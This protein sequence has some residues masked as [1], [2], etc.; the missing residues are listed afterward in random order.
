MSSHPHKKKH[1]REEVQGVSKLKNLL[2]ELEQTPVP[3]RT[4]AD[5]ICQTQR[6]TASRGTSCGTSR[7]LVR[8]Q[9]VPD[10]ELAVKKEIEEDTLEY[11]SIQGNP[12]SVTG[13]V[14]SHLPFD[15]PSAKTETPGTY[16]PFDTRSKVSFAG[17]A[18]QINSKLIQSLVKQFAG[19]MVQQ[20]KEDIQ[21]LQTRLA[22]AE[23]I[24]AEL[25]A[26]IETLESTNAE[27]GDLITS[28]QQHLG[29]DKPAR[30]SLVESLDKD[31]EKTFAI[32]NRLLTD[33]KHLQ[34]DNEKMAK[35]A[36]QE[37]RTRV[38][39]H[40]DIASILRVFKTQIENRHSEIPASSSQRGRTR[41]IGIH[42]RRHG[43]NTPSSSSRSRS[44][45]QQPTTAPLV[46]STP[47][48]GKVPKPITP[49]KWTGDAEKLD[50]FINALNIYMRNEYW[51]GLSERSKINTALSFIISER[52]HNF[53]RDIA[54]EKL[55][56]NTYAEFLVELVLKF[57]DPHVHARRLQE[58][59]EL[60]QGTKSVAEFTCKFNELC[61]LI[62]YERESRAMLEKYRQGLGRKWFNAVRT[63]DSP[64]TTLAE[65]QRIAEETE[66]RKERDHKTMIAATHKYSTPGKGI[67]NLETVGDEAKEINA[68]TF[69]KKPDGCMKCGQKHGFQEKDKCRW[70][71]GMRCGHCQKVGH[72][73]FAC[74][75]RLNGQ[76]RT[77]AKAK[78]VRIVEVE[79]LNP[80]NP[81]SSK[82]VDE[83]PKA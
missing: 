31:M 52:T 68:L 42:R 20:M 19:K 77:A 62:P 67:R 51:G 48:S 13:S 41:N 64:P 74:M 6:Q 76:P 12:P 27:Q 2:R 46:T 56:F 75:A 22:A 43:H 23:R 59:D 44:R 39:E 82:S 40:Q 36:K 53:T 32:D 72:L 28:W 4:R 38:S 11:R 18:H 45:P 79:T 73:S 29:E 78:E 57:G 54:A 80:P 70:K 10:P 63:R 47:A 9:G 14:N 1:D 21:S 58:F 16:I 65:W 8:S 37:E 55:V 83:T 35:W 25:G 61:D 30:S 26:R 17:G 49:D 50:V 69:T 7:Q 5:T 60:Q 81:S 71:E 15:T 34:R 33:V 66:I 24:N 3:W